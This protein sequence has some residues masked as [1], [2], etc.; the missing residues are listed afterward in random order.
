MDKAVA[1]VTNPLV[2]V[3]VIAAL[4]SITAA[5]IA[6]RSSRTATAGAS[7]VATLSHRIA[8]LDAEAEQ[9][10]EDYR[11]FFEAA[12]T[13]STRSNLNVIL[14]AGEILSSNPRSTAALAEAADKFCLALARGLVA[15]EGKTAAMSVEGHYRALRAAFTDSVRAIAEE[16]EKVLAAK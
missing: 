4:A 7:A 12:G 1:L 3:A 6:H 15:A 16:R 14:A 8:R 10:R 9:L 11:R 2:I 13:L 5:V